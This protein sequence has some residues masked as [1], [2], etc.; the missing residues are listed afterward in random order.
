MRI[1]VTGASG[2]YG[3]AAVEGLLEKVS[4]SDLILIT[5]NPAKLAEFAARGAEVR[6]G[7]F[8]DGE[9]LRTAFAGGDIMLLISTNRVGQRIPQHRAAIDA[10]VAAGVKHIVYTSFIGIGPDN[11][12]LVNRDHLATEQ[13][14]Q[15]SGIHWTALRDSQYADAIVQAVAPMVLASGVWRASAAEGKVAFVTR[16]D[17]VA[18]AVA[19]LTT[20]GH[21]DRVYNITGP[22]LL[23]FRDAAGILAAIGGRPIDYQVVSDTEMYATFDALGIPRE[24]QDDQMIQ[25]FAWSSDD[26]VSFETA[27]RTGYFAVQSDDVEQ[28]LGR[29]P[30]SFRSFAEEHADLLQAAATGTEVN[31]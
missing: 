16:R 8:D 31:A 26:M 28:L 1:I 7:D 29:K 25:G 27:L 14:L 12:A 2:N 4:A 30:Q 11:P 17:C 3:R 9:S 13:M 5:R 21:A 19:V 22:D 15:T 18:C 6:A 20:S 23:S 24:A 10:A